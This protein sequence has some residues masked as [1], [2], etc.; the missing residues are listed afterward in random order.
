M[1]PLLEIQILKKPRANIPTERQLEILRYI[2][3]GYS[4]EEISTKLGCTAATVRTHVDVL[5]RRINAST[6]AHAVGKAYR[7]GWFY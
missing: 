3:F 5:L 4:N 1:N 2:A 6:R 7:N